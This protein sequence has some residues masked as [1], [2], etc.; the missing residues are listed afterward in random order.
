MDQDDPEKR[1]ADFERQLANASGGVG[2]E[3][4]R[5]PG[6]SR[7]PKARS[8]R[9]RRAGGIRDRL[10]TIWKIV[11]SG[12]IAVGVVMALGSAVH[13]LYAYHVGTST[14][15]TVDHCT[16]QYRGP[17]SCTVA[18]SIGGTSSS[19]PIVGLKGRRSRSARGHI[20][21]QMIESERGDTAAG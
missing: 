12:A 17:S 11:L 10:W 13:N 19:G 7:A 6:Q 4:R 3:L 2:Q 14:T 16:P 5:F 20:F 8:P 15:A 1:F 21:R 18:W 9:Q